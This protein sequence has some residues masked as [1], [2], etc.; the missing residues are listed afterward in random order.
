VT[1]AFVRR[2]VADIWSQAE[3]PGPER[4]VAAPDDVAVAEDQ[5]AP[6]EMDVGVGL[7]VLPRRVLRAVELVPVLGSVLGRMGPDRAR[8]T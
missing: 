4:A 7:A 6:L 5:V 3:V 8:Q 2:F 1:I